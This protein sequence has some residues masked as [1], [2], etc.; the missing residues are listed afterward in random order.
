MSSVFKHSSHMAHEGLSCYTWKNWDLNTM[1][2]LNCPML[3][4]LG[5][6]VCA[7]VF[8]KTNPFFLPS[9]DRCTLYT[10][11]W[12]REAHLHQHIWHWLC[13]H[14]SKNVIPISPL[15]TVTEKELQEHNVSVN[16]EI[17]HIFC[18]HVTKGLVRLMYLLN[19]LQ[20]HTLLQTL[21]T[22]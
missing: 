15:K 5:L 11:L 3:Q 14:C 16:K 1:T 22:L 21:K 8:S 18:P 12:L 10:D 13:G 19:I 4:Q 9:T 6:H 7:W 17:F 20:A 2:S